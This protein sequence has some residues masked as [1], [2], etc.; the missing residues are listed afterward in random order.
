ML[1]RNFLLIEQVEHVTQ[2]FLLIEQAGIEIDK[3][4]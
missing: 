3:Y 2:E 4:L 1:P